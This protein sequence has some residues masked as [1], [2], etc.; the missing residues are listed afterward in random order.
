[1]T[2]FLFHASSG[3]TFSPCRRYRYRLWREWGDP[4]N[5]VVFCAV[6]PST[7]DESEDDATIRKE[8]GFAKRWSFEAI[9]KINCF[10]W[11]STD[12][13]GLLDTK[14]P[15][16]P[17][18]DDAIAYAVR[19][20]KRVVL[21]W[22]SHAPVK[23]LLAERAIRVRQIVHEW[24]GM[25]ELGHLGVCKDGHP[26]HPLMLSYETPFVSLKDWRQAITQSGD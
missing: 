4:A 12:I 25:R 9:E 2:G 22:G 23:R 3:A 19:H 6:N 14:D 18:N 20:A 13:R 10:A 5:R 1:V 7:A 17:D 26:R 8:I 16:G 24:V 11:R 21:C 15:V